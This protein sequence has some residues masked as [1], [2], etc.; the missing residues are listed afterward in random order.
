MDRFAQSESSVG[1]RSARTAQPF[2]GWWN[3]MGR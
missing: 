3:M 1:R 2:E